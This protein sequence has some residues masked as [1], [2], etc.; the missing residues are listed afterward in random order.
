MLEHLKET[1]PGQVCHSAV[2]KPWDIAYSHTEHL[3]SRYSMHSYAARVAI[4]SKA[5]CLTS[6]VY[7]HDTRT[8]HRRALPPP[9]ILALLPGFKRKTT[10]ERIASAMS[11]INRDD[12]AQTSDPA[13]N[14]ENPLA[15]RQG[16]ACW[17]CAGSGSLVRLV[18]K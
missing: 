15:L 12:G 7:T 11:A 13:V 2:S 14:Q 1:R 17:A 5:P 9:Q 16:E 8:L 18:P 3:C 10:R 4:C 6:F